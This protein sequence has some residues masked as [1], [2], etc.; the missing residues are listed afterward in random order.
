M[1]NIITQILEMGLHE[2]EEAEQ[3]DL[4][5]LLRAGH[6]LM[7]RR[8]PKSGHDPKEN[9]LKENTL[10]ARTTVTDDQAIT[11]TFDLTDADKVAVEGN[12]APVVVTTVDDAGADVS[13]W[14]NRRPRTS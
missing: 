11:T 5:T 12:P 2:L 1:T 3:D 6:S 7:T 9:T 8:P 13:K 14:F 4:L 10:M